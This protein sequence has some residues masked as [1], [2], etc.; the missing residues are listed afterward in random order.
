M[1]FFGKRVLFLGAHPDDIEIGCGALIH[2]I[3]NKTEILCVTLSDNQKNPDLAK[4]KNEH[5]R[6]MKILG[7]PEEKIVFG[8]FTT[9][10]F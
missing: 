8:P 10:I 4:V 6:S 1:N 3:V 7:V 9:R 2:N 5:L